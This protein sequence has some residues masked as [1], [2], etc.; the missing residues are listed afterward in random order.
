MVQ[1]STHLMNTLLIRS[2]LLPILLFVLACQPSVSEKQRLAEQEQALLQK[3]KE[4]LEK[5]QELLHKEQQI[6]QQQ[7]EQSSQTETDNPPEE[8]EK[9]LPPTKEINHPIRLGTHNITLQWI[10]WDH[11]GTVELSYGDDGRYKIV[12]GQKSRE[13]DDYLKIDGY[14]TFSTV[15]EFTFEGTVEYLVSHNNGGEAC[16]KT[17]P[18]HF[19]ASGQR[20]YWRMQEKT[21]CEGGM[22]TDYVDIYF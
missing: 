19:K 13:N 18:L 5:E 3:E 6:K 15:K 11:P 17:G 16:I 4:L 8:E 14:A 1:E 12:G 7:A 20:K 10:S 21:N 9:T 22:L 2:L